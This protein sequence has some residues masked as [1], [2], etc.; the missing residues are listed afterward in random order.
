MC[1]CSSRATMSLVRL[2]VEGRAVIGSRV[3]PRKWRGGGRRVLSFRYHF[4]SFVPLSLLS[5]PHAAFEG[6]DQR[7]RQDLTC[8]KAQAATT[9]WLSSHATARPGARSSAGPECRTLHQRT[10]HV[11]RAA[12][13]EQCR[14]PHR[15]TCCTDI[16]RL[17]GHC[18]P[19]R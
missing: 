4:H 2:R 9:P 3:A 13:R 11:A 19:L 17:M 15:W 7:Q 8:K 14:H 16:E 12:W 10:H 6:A 18:R 5:Q 1:C